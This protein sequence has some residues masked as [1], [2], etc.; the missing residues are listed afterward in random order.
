VLAISG[1]ACHLWAHCEYHLGET[2]NARHDFVRARQHF[3]R[4]LNV[5]FWSSETQFAAA[6][7]A[8]RSG[9]LAAAANHLRA[10]QNIGGH[11][12]GVDLEFTLLRLQQGDVKSVERGLEGLLER[13]DPDT[14]PILEVLTPAY[15][16]SYQLDKALE[17][18]RRWL[19]REPDRV[20]AWRYRAQIFGRKQS[21][22]ELVA[23]YQRILDLDPDDDESRLRLAAELI[24]SRQFAEALEQYRDLRTRRGDRPH[25]VIGMASCLT[26]LSQPNEARRLLDRVLAKDAHNA[27]ALAERGRLALQY[28]SPAEA[29]TWL[30]RAVAENPSEHDV[31]YS[32][33]QCLQ[34]VGKKTEAA[35]IEAKIKRLEADLMGLREAMRQIIV[36]PHDPEPRYRAGLLLLRNGKKDEGLR[37]LTSALVENPRHKPTHQALADYYDKAGDRARAAQHRKL[38]S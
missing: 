9:D 24:A 8:R 1:I 10:V 30:R 16:Q 15:I 4:S 7:S 36:H 19:E 22:A 23:S 18:T 2:A 34:R 13:N 25:I 33:F 6:R 35:E 14:I 31:L 20:E 28:E 32:L 11:D 21:S 3:E 26:S 38:T 12:D 17:C 37:W 27:P 29:E 5:W